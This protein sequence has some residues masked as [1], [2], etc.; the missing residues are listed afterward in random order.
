MPEAFARFFTEEETKA[1]YRRTM[2]VLWL[3]NV[4]IIETGKSKPPTEVV[5]TPGSSSLEALNN[6]ARLWGVG[7]DGVTQQDANRVEVEGVNGLKNACHY[8]SIKVPKG[9]TRKMMPSREK[10]LKIRDALARSVYDEQFNMFFDKFTQQ[11]GGDECEQKGQNFLG[12]LDIFGFEQVEMQN[13]IEYTYPGDDPKGTPKT[14]QV[15]SFEQFC[16]NYCN[17]MLQHVF[18]QVIFD[19]EKK[20][21]V[22]QLG[23]EIKLDMTDIDNSD[24]IQLMD[25]TKSH[26]SIIEVLND[27]TEK[28][29]RGDEEEVGD[30]RALM[31]LTVGSHDNHFFQTLM[32]GQEHGLDHRDQKMNTS[33]SKDN[34]SK[35]NKENK[36]NCDKKKTDPHHHGY[37]PTPNKPKSEQYHGQ[38]FDLDHYASIVR[39]DVKDW[40]AKNADRLTIEINECLKASS[41]PF[42]RAIYEQKYASPDAGASTVVGLFRERLHDLGVIHSQRALLDES[43]APA[44]PRPV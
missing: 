32:T 14:P 33:W 8:S 44:R 43:E 20:L 11:L 5:V 28:S 4:E 9:V 40:V 1:I 31:K 29:L 10:A 16:I 13:I 17:E 7:V 42:L 6:V 39:Y 21:Y 37:A 35:V 23:Y 34:P 24:T 15:N 25:N 30:E 41:D 22:D 27:A 18:V 36:K 2:G 38:G 26:S 3:G 12:V 19:M